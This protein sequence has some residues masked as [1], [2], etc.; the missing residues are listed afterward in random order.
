MYTYPDLRRTPDTDSSNPRGSIE[1]SLRTTLYTNLLIKNLFLPIN[2]IQ[3]PLQWWDLTK[4]KIKQY[5]IFQSKQIL[6]E[7]TRKQN[8]LQQNLFKAKQS[9]QYETIS[10]ISNQIDQIEQKKKLGS[11]IRS[12]VPPL[13]SIDDLSLLAPIIENLTQSKSLLPTDSNTPRP[14][15]STEKYNSYNFNSFL[16]FLKNL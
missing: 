3:Q 5:L 7:T 9:N 12:R 16:S 4:F 6:K 1:P 15:I 2:L 13:S 10:N 14:I 11:Q 8:T